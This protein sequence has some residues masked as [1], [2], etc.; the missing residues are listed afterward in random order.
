[1]MPKNYLA[2]AIAVLLAACSGEDATQPSGPARG[3]HVWK[4]QTD[5]LDKARDVED[6]LLDAGSQQRR[7]IDDMA[8]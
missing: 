3:D 5:M 4:T 6:V 1:M 8:R 2:F 7:Q